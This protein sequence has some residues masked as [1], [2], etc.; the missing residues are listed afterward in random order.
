[1]PAKGDTW[2]LW[3]SAAPHCLPV[4]RSTRPASANIW[5]PKFSI[6]FNAPANIPP[7]VCA[8][9]RRTT[10]SAPAGALESSDRHRTL[11]RHQV[12]SPRQ[13]FH[14]LFPSQWDG[15]R[16]RSSPLDN[17]L[18]PAEYIRTDHPPGRT[19]HARRGRRGTPAR[20]C[21]ILCGVGNAALQWLGGARAPPDLQHHPARRRVVSMPGATLMAAF[22]P[23]GPIERCVRSMAA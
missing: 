18:H 13:N 8:I 4:S 6:A 1:M 11:P 7:A 9:C 10:R 12:I 15:R 21:S 2:R 3:M 5:N 14:T 17:A 23:G 16:A 22:T 20:R 19:E